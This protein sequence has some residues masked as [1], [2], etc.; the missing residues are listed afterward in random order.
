MPAA[1]AASSGAAP[2]RIVAAWT[3]SGWRAAKSRMCGL[4]PLDAID[5]Q[6]RRSRAR[7][8]SRRVVRVLDERPTLEARRRAEPGALGRDDAQSALDPRRPIG[9]EREPRAGRARDAEDRPAG[10]DAG[11]APGDDATVRSRQSMVGDVGPAARRARSDRSAR[12]HVLLP[13]M[14]MRTGPSGRGPANSPAHDAAAAPSTVIPSSSV[15]TAC[16]SWSAASVTVASRR[17][18]RPSARRRAGWRPAWRSR[19]RRSSAASVSIGAPGLEAE[20]HRRGAPRPGCRRRG[21]RG[22][23][24]AAT[25]RRR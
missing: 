10:R 20:G 25:T 6:P 9:T 3:R 8:G 12:S 15:R 14:T 13:V 1:S 18:G 16:A 23:S 5:R 17:R 4:A 24:P 7:R 2:T 19:R 11:L 21:S 22:G